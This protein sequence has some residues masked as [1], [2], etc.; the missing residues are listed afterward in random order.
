MRSVRNSNIPNSINNQLDHKML[1]KRSI[2]NNEKR[3]KNEHKSNKVIYEI[4]DR[5][6]LQDVKTKLIS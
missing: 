1:I 4:G 2:E 6:R 5:V 3:I